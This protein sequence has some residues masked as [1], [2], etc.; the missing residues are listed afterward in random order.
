MELE[1]TIDKA[2]PVRPKI[3]P[4][5]TN[6]IIKTANPTV[7]PNNV[8]LVCSLPRNFEFNMEVMVRGMMLRIVI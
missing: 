7:F 5:I 8:G 4:R 6:K 1:I 3:P 2:R